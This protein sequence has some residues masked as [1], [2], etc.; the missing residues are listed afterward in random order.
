MKKSKIS[1]SDELESVMGIG[2]RLAENLQKR[3]IRK[4][5]DLCHIME[6]L[7]LATQLDLKYKPERKI[8]REEID[9]IDEVLKKIFKKQ[10][11]RYLISGSYRREKPFS[12]D[13]DI[14][15]D[16]KCLKNK[17]SS[18]DYLA[19]IS[20]MINQ[21]RVRTPTKLKLIEPY[22]SGPDR[23]SALFKMQKT[24]PFKYYKVDFFITPPEEWV[25]AVVYTT[26]SQKFNIRM[27]AL[28]KHKGYKLNQRGLFKIDGKPI[29]VKSERELFKILGMTY[30]NPRER[31][32]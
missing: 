11:C 19:T 26:G 14:L 23:I 32:I 25:F 2:K 21:S 5:A 28:A 20:D 3:G 22:S 15:I 9:K 8:P 10:S 24:R 29:Q 12:H 7:P 1:P 16:S 30:K 18:G 31:N 17:S 27:R 6:E 13:I 4:R